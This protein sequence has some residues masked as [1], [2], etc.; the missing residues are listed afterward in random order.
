MDMSSQ[1]F[2]S[3]HFLAAMPDMEDERFYRSVIYICNH[4]P[5]GAMG[6]VLNRP[7]TS[8]FLDLVMQLDLVAEGQPQLMSRAVFNRPVHFGGPVEPGRGFVL[9]SDDY[10]GPT[11][12]RVSAGVCLTS[13]IDILRLISTGTGPRHALVALGFA[14]WTGGQ[15]EAEIAANSW[16]VAPASPEMIFEGELGTIYERVLASIGVDLSRFVSEAGHS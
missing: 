9:H 16:L 1:G 14:G 4:S 12:T 11:T 13:T 5:E 3:G 6:F 15:L 8:R 7:H 2:L 10:I